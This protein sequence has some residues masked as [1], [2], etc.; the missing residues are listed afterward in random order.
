MIENK[1]I[2]ECNSII[3]TYIIRFIFF[4]IFDLTDNNKIK[5]NQAALRIFRYYNNKRWKLIENTRNTVDGY[6]QIALKNLKILS[7][8]R[9]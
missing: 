2:Y 8:F 6:N 9:Y 1:Q 5:I 3:N 4:F 7:N